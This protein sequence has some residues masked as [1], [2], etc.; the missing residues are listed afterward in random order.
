MYQQATRPQRGVALEAVLPGWGSNHPLPPPRRT[1][2]RKPPGPG[3]SAGWNPW[4]LRG[5][6]RRTM[7]TSL[8]KHRRLN[9][10]LRA[11][12][13]QMTVVLFVRFIIP[14]HLSLP[15]SRLPARFSSAAHTL[16]L[17]FCFFFVAE[18]GWTGFS[19]CDWFELY[20][21][22]HNSFFVCLSWCTTQ[23]YVNK[24]LRP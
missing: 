14:F 22:L 8:P 19:C 11:R 15:K 20:F 17:A 21:L 24:E 4:S 9:W 7:F 18:K 12:P 16:Q 6:E 1:E 2:R 13:P 3:A 5:G 23:G 10:S